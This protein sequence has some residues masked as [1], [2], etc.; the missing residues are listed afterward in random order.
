[1]YHYNSINDIDDR[2]IP[3]AYRDLL[4]NNLIDVPVDWINHR[5]RYSRW[6]LHG[7]VN[8]D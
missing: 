3:N 2:N 5:R 6:D 1:M 7:K 8:V 4:W